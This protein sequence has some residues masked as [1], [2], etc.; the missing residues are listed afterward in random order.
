MS[1]KVFCL[2][3]I[4]DIIEWICEKLKSVKVVSKNLSFKEESYFS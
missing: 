4:G 2:I 3:R 1:D